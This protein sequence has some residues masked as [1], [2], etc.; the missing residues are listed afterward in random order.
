[1]KYPARVEEEFKWARTAPE[2]KLVN[3]MESD[4]LER[5]KMVK[6]QTSPDMLNQ[7]THCRLKVEVQYLK[8]T[9]APHLK[10]KK[11]TDTDPVIKK[12]KIVDLP[13][14]I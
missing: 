6:K 4:I 7:L 14:D 1:M 13:I 10:F 9:I 11:S 12:Y 8:Q 3:K 2:A 5:V